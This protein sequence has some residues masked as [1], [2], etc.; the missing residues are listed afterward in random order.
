[1]A[2][3][4]N[5]PSPEELRRRIQER[6]EKMKQ[7]ESSQSQDT[8]KS[9]EPS[10]S[11]TD[12]P[13]SE[14]KELKTE[15]IVP[16]RPTPEQRIQDKPKDDAT[17]AKDSESNEDKKI[18]SAPKTQP[19][20]QRKDDSAPK[21]K[22]AS[23]ESMSQKT[24]PI[25][26]PGSDS[27]QPKI[28]VKSN[29]KEAPEIKKPPFSQGNNPKTKPIAS[30][31]RQTSRITED[32]EDK[33]SN[34]AGLV[35]ILIIL[36]LAVAGLFTWKFLESNKLQT[37]VTEVKNENENL[38]K[39]KEKIFNDL[40]SLKADYDKLETSNEK[41][42]AELEAKNQQLEEALKKINSHNLDKKELSYLRRQVLLLKQSK[43]TF[44]AQIDSLTT[45]N[46]ELSKQN[47]EARIAL[48][49][50]KTTNDQLTAQVTQGKKIKGLN[51]KVNTYNVKG[52]DTDKAKKIDEIETCITL[53]E[54]PIAEPGE[55]SI[56]MRIVSPSGDIL[57]SSK[58][59]IFEAEGLE[60]AYSSV[61]SVF[62]QN[63]TL[64]TCIKYSPQEGEISPGFYDIEIFTDGEMIG[65]TNIQ[66][67]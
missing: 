20:I 8:P 41:L 44:M 56:F 63:K 27:A 37:E 42:N 47:E 43:E 26:R 66:F 39:Q 14:K 1:M 35:V 15:P 21:E 57:I 51:L 46:Q 19:I 7:Q 40:K 30:E 38:I 11:P 55:K 36:L 62:Y 33:K 23:N 67:K 17:K 12:E 48:Q 61:G 59:N 22:P 25:Q 53:I 24:A 54:N 3:E 2:E 45:A 18:S 32:R 58:D 6:L 13:K 52:K 4:N 16:P 10:Q 64:E 29:K 28:E 65:S 5:S 9:P 50:T 31:P 60:L 34:K 49:E